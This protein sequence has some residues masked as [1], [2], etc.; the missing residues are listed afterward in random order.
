MLVKG[1]VMTKTQLVC[2]T[3]L[4]LYKSQ[5]ADS[6]GGVGDRISSRAREKVS[7]MPAFLVL[8]VCRHGP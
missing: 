5:F 8:Y 3:D 4:H 6:H 7:R 2:N 1:P